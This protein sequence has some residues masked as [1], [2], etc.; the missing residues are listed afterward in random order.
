MKKRFQ[1]V[2]LQ[3]ENQSRDQ[4]ET[5]LDERYD[6]LMRKA[7]EG[8]FTSRLECNEELDEAKK[9]YE[10]SAAGVQKEV[11]D[12]VLLEKT[13]RL[14]QKAA[15]FISK[16]AENELHSKVR[17]L[18]E[19]NMGLEKEVGE[20]KLQ[21]ESGKSKFSLEKQGLES[22]NVQLKLQLKMEEERRAH[23]EKDRNAQGEHQTARLRAQERE[24]ED[25][26]AGLREEL[27]ELKKQK[28]EFE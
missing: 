14:V 12:A 25:R 11:R 7:R 26:E 5:L 2:K 4:C 21:V 22:E 1:E 3:C 24:F 28:S 15:N 27:R 10:K 13:G 19:K 8:C 23:W 18:Q 20:W 9:E 16:Q 6:E 17:Y